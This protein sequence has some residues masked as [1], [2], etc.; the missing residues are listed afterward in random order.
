MAT[1]SVKKTTTVSTSVSST[2]ATPIGNISGG[3]RPSSPLSPTR[4]SRLQEKEE[5][6]GLNDRLAVYI[7][8][9]RQLEN[10]NNR[11]QIQVQTNQETVTREVTSIKSMYES[12]LSE[13]RRLL[14]DVAKEKARIQ[15]DCTKYKSEND[16]LLAKLAKKDK[17]LM[18]AEKNAAYHENKVHDVQARLNQALNDR[19]R[20][21]DENKELKAEVEKLA[22]Q[23]ASTRQKLEEETLK[24]VDLENRIQSL[25]EELTFK[26]Q[27]HEKELTETRTRKQVEISE[28]DGKL[29]ERYEQKLTETLQELRDQYESQMRENRGEIESL[30][31][32]KLEDLKRM[33]DQYLRNSSSVR[34]EL[35]QFKSRVSGL[36]SRISE[37]E[38]QNASLQNRIKDLEQ[39]LEE[40]RNAHLA[41]LA[42]K[43]DHIRRLQ[44]EM[45][46]QIK[47]YEDLMGI[48]VA[49]DLEIAAYRK[50]LE[51]EEARLNI[52]PTGTPRDL[53]L[54]QTRSTPVR[55]T[56]V[57]S[58]KRKRTYMSHSEE[59]S[60]S[61]YTSN[62]SATGDVEI[63]EQDVEGKYVRLHNKG[64]KDINI[65]GWQLLRKAGEK[66]CN[67]KFHRSVV[68]KAGTTI[69]V[70]SSDSETTHAPPAELVM[71]G[72]QWVTG[73][74]VVTR[75]LSNTGEELA[76]RETFRQIL[77]GSSLR[78][79]DV[80]GEMG[81]EEIYHQQGD[82][83]NPERCSIM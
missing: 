63:I 69:T 30:Y 60:S 50:L 9:V 62:A 3:G 33:N 80:G 23:L 77:S 45:N 75:L 27:I 66:T 58:R 25:R 70:W 12:E 15:I 83:Q 17:D 64:S 34:E 5:L 71:K 39:M 61:N 2:S 13:A 67:Y 38:A 40:E 48:K 51:S 46:Q 19:K 59:T 29:Q 43:E 24:R 76:S 49:L 41:L 79:S 32:G 7:E 11:L 1:K 37:L 22:K 16:D 55:R 6:S 81:Y 54:Q 36:Q 73:T 53:M 20:F 35:I 10:E 42:D 21:E 44:D 18:T 78:V 26:E 14:D 56:P 47:D 74:N 4:L 31:E 8:R 57:G 72:Q 52:T 82:P 28:I 65:G 68:I